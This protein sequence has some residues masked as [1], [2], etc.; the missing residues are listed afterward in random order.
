MVSLKIAKISLEMF[1]IFIIYV[2]L[3]GNSIVSVQYTHEVNAETYTCKILL[4][5]DVETQT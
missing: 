1:F 5:P 2:L 4:E 3:I